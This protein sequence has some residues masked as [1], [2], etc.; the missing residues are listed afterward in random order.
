MH[1]IKKLLGLSLLITLLPFSAFSEPDL[2]VGFSGPLTGPAAAWGIDVKNVLIFANEKLAQGRYKFVI[3]DDKCDPKEA[4]TIAHKFAGPEKLRYVFLVAGTVTLAAAPVYGRANM[5]V[6]APIVTPRAISNLGDYLFRTTPGDG[7]A[8]GVLA[9]KI[10]AKYRSVAVL[11]EQSEYSTGFLEDFAGAAKRKGLAISNEDYLQSETDF[12]SRLLR[13]ASKQPEAMFVNANTERAFALILKQARDLK[14][15]LPIFGAYIP[16]S[17]AFLK[18]AGN[19]AEGIIFPDYPDARVLLNAEGQALYKEFVAQYGKLQSFEYA[20]PAVLE[21]FR[22]FDAAVRDGA[23][24]KGYL[25]SREFNGTMGKFSFDQHGDVI[26]I[27]PALKIIRGG[28]P[29]LLELTQGG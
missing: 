17:A 19:D 7:V 25:H 22:A 8:A 1:T 21:A 24:P 26:G 13:L 23:D 20:F 4:V 6:M 27:Q 29:G 2:R 9:E 15:K 10:A 11:T 18:L 28:Q 3:E 14:I 12:R 16:G 5:L